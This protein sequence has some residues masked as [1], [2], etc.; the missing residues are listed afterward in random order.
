MAW[1]R[2]H[3]DKQ[4]LEHIVLDYH[5]AH[6]RDGQTNSGQAGRRRERKREKKERQEQMR[7]GKREIGPA[8]CFSKGMQKLI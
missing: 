7:E 5:T 8:V 6:Q 4:M 1:V 2:H 3:M